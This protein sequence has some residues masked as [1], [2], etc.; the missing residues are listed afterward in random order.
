MMF[1]RKGCFTGRD[2]CCLFYVVMIF[3]VKNINFVANMFTKV[4]SIL[5]SN[6]PTSS[7]MLA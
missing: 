2:H 5:L 7:L 3:S 4:V 6:L 1:K